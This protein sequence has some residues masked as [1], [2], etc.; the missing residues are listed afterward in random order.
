MNIY[1]KEYYKAM[2]WY[3][4]A[5][6]EVER[7]NLLSKWKKKFG[8][9]VAVRVSSLEEIDFSK[10][11][12]TAI[13]M[14]G[15]SS[16]G[17]STLAHKLKDKYV[18]WEY[19][20]MDDEGACIIQQFLEKHMSPSEE[21]LDSMIHQNFGDKLELFS[22]LKKNVIMDGNWVVPPS[23]AAA[24]NT[25]RRLG[26]DTVIMF[27]LLNIPNDIAV[28]RIK[29]RAIDLVIIGLE[30]E[31]AILKSRDLR[32]FIEHTK[33]KHGWTDE[34]IM[35]TPMFIEQFAKYR[36]YYFSVE[37]TEKALVEQKELDLFSIGADFWVEHSFG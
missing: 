34:M 29:K 18:D 36:M 19:L 15:Q 2:D 24:I 28:E 27:S 12:L 3:S 31:K 9:R 14:I 5:F 35:N 17:K 16:V 30:K 13:L 11:G 4:S 22:K 7:E 20:S 26:Y 23:R 33:A 32:L 25:L 21:V 8:E 10:T 6:D 1:E 37:P